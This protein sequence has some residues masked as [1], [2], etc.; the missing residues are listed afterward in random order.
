[1]NRIS[2]PPICDYEGSDY[3]KVFWDQGARDYE[4]QV[5]AIAIRRLLRQPGELLLEIGAGAG[6]NT[7]RY[8]NF[9]QIVLLD[10]SISQLEQAQNRL[11]QGVRFLYVAADAYHLPFVANLFDAATMI[12]TIHHL[13]DPNLA[14]H[15]VRRV[16]KAGAVFLLEYA[17]KQ[18]LKAIFRY[19]LGRQTWNP[20]DSTPIEFA[21]LNF[22][23][24]PK[25]IRQWLHKSGFILKR[26]LTVSHFRLDFLKRAFPTKLLV[27]LDS[28]AQYTGAWWQLSPSVFTLAQASGS[29]VQEPTKGFF[30]CPRC[31][32][33]Q[34]DHLPNSL[35]CLKCGEKWEIRQGIYIFR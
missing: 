21:E 29:A 7:L 28:L 3:Q 24:H 20:F 26:Q 19:L 13:A 10:Y 23:F 32:G 15:E 11:G 2:H 35:L 27:A 25:A 8:P 31:Q 12:R 1:M 4:D 16:L 30:A 33:D 22:D 9:R 6:R 14:L 18:N 34:F 5:E 17:N